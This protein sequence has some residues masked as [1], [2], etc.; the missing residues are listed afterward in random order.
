ML[1][2]DFDRMAD[3]LNAQAEMRRQEPLS[4][5]SLKLWFNA[6][7]PFTVAAFEAAL[8]N[9]ILEPERGRFMPQPADLMAFLEG[10]SSDRGNLAWTKLETAVQRVGT[11]ASVV[12]DD[13]LI[14]RVVADM[15]G[16]MEFGRKT[17]DAWPFVKN[18]FVKRYRDYA[19]R[20]ASPD[21]QPVLVGILEAG[22]GQTGQV[23]T[24]P[25]MFVGDPHLCRLVMERGV[26]EDLVQIGLAP[27]GN[28]GRGTKRLGAAQLRAGVGQ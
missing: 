22:N 4:P 18:E 21:Y 24:A 8:Q 26:R 14:H 11:Y 25:P 6:M 2:R 17:T 23:H 5:T 1:D 7:K 16:W 15:G 20:R 19:S 9:H 28:E 3:L 12:F 13:A 27:G 10:T